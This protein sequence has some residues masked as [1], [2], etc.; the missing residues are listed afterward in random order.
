M[1]RKIVLKKS[2]D[3][4]PECNFCLQVDNVFEIRN[5]L[6][7]GFVMQICGKCLKSLD[8]QFKEIV[9]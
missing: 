3:R 2:K 9:K 1:E 4:Y 5:N 8:E 7:C 6:N